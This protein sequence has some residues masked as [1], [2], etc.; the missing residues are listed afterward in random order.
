MPL[1]DR[2]PVAVR[3][4]TYAL[5]MLALAGCGQ[6]A[7]SPVPTRSLG[8]GERWLPVANWTGRLCGGGGFVGDFRLHG[9]PDDPSTAWMTYPD[10]S[11]KELAWSPG[12]SARFIPALEVVGPDGNVI[13][14]EGSL[15]TGGCPVGDPNVLFVEF[16]TPS[17]REP[18][19]PAGQ[20]T[21]VTY[22]R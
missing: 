8:P 9:S 19:A 2:D 18:T 17:A 5:L 21:L 16:Q 6:T 1:R 12:T 13:A 22:P 10:G 3:L 15:V 7:T 14:R 20:T 11:R 4:L